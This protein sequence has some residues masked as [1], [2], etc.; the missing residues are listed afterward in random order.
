MISLGA[1]AAARSLRASPSATMHRVAMVAATRACAAPPPV[2]GRASRST[3]R[4][5]PRVSD[6]GRAVRAHRLRSLFTCATPRRS[7][8]ARA[9]PSSAPASPSRADSGTTASSSAPWSDAEGDALRAHYAREGWLVVRAVADARLVADLQ[10]AADALQAE[11][12]TLETSRRDRGVF[13]E[14]QSAS[15]RKRESAVYP[16]ALPQGHVPVQAPRR[17]SSWWFRSCRRRRRRTVGVP[18]ILSCAVDQINFKPPRVGTG[19]PWHQDASFLKPLARERFDAHGGVNVVVAL[20]RLTSTTEVS[21]FSAGRTCA[22]R[23]ALRDAYDTSSASDAL[24]LFDESKRVVPALDPGDAVFFHPLLAHGSGPGESRAK[25]ARR[26]ALVRESGET[27][28]GGRSGSNICTVVFFSFSGARRRLA[29]R[30]LDSILL[31]ATPSARSSSAH[32]R[33]VLV[34]F[35]HS[36]T[37]RTALTQPL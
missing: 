31:E 18:G 29:I 32:P 25:E 16:G 15:G 22:A 5:T 37:A 10:T 28:C 27:Q 9:S 14:V 6:A 12:S 33:R 11:A 7:P 13:F 19:F 4:S 36:A 35:A 34:S 2:T 8:V 23:R 17:V 1:L 26:H 3:S 20:T 24:G 30:C 21:R